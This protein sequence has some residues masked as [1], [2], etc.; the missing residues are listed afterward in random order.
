MKNKS[1]TLSNS[2]I[3][4]TFNEEKTIEKYLDSIFA[5]TKMPNEIIIV[6]A[7]SKDN[8]L[9]LIKK[10]QSKTKRHNTKIKLIIKKGNRSIGRNEAIKNA[11]GDIILCSDAGCILDKDWVKNISKPFLNNSIDV[12]AGYYKGVASTILQKCLIPYV[13]IPQDKVN[14]YTFLPATR[15]MAF[16]KSVWEKV[17]GFN[18]KFSHNEDY[19]FSKELQKKHLKIFFENSAIVYW[20]PPKSWNEIFIMFYRF[21]KGDIQAKIIR[22]KVILIFVRYI[23]YFLLLLSYFVFYI[24]LIL[25]VLFFILFL[26][27]IWA[28]EKNYRYVKNLKAVYLLPLLQFISDIA[29]IKGSLEGFYNVDNI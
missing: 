3:T 8:T 1:I 12:V 28:I 23:V 20:L 19:V 25:Y 11:T 14:P 24:S 27:I 16:R 9:N 13:L 10:Y 7:Q 6:D 21:A 22:P 5:Q 4:T 15:S 29:V 18:E 26:Y 17:G 2:F